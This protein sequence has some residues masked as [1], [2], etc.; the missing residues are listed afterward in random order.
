MNEKN[1]PV[2]GDNGFGV[3]LGKAHTQIIDQ[4]IVLVNNE[5][6]CPVGSVEGD[7]L[8]KQVDARKHQLRK[9]K[10]WACDVVTLEQAR[11]KGAESIRLIDKKAGIEWET[12]LDSLFG[13]GS[14]EINRGYGCQRVLPLIH[15]TKR[16]K[17]L[18]FQLSFS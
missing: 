3:V 14:F 8:I 13:R 2:A 11:N 10:A 16:G 9:P 12:R 1:K 5:A 7:V 4:S 17:G 15:W 6:G 18:P